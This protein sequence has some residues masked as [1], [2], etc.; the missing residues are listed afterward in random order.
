ME[1]S[2]CFLP[3]RPVIIYYLFVLTIFIYLMCFMDLRLLAKNTIKY[4][5]TSDRKYLWLI[6][7]YSN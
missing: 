7:I 2:S 5:Y 1:S 4:C 6:S 3:V